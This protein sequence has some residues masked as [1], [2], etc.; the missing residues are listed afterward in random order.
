MFYRKLISFA[1]VLSLAIAASMTSFAASSNALT[2]VNSAHEGSDEHRN[3]R[4]LQ[5]INLAVLIQDDL[6]S[7]VSNEIQATRDFI[8]SLPKG[9]QVMVGYIT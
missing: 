5:P 7:Q 2:K 9:S 8:K 6:T 4:V 3:T 1:V